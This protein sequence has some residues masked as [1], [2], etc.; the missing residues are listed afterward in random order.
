MSKL[1]VVDSRGSL[2]AV[3]GAFATVARLRAFACRRRR[4]PVR[5]N[6]RI[7]WCSAWPLGHLRRCRSPGA[8][9]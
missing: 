1:T 7:S 5:S 9:A 2:Q 6:D 3:R 8:R 4:R